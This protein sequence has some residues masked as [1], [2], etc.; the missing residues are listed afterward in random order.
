MGQGSMQGLCYFLLPSASAGLWYYLK[1]ILNI[2][3]F[4]RFLSSVHM[5]VHT[6]TPALFFIFSVLE[7]KP[8]AFCMQDKHSTTNPYPQSLKF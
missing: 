8:T 4:A 7:V 3:P 5:H 1:C 2:Y 6:H